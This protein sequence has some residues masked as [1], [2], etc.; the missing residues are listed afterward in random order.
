MEDLA[1]SVSGS[2]QH[3]ITLYAS[4][5]VHVGSRFVASFP[6][7]LTGN[8]QR[9]FGPPWATYIVSLEMARPTS[10]STGQKEV[11]VHPSHV[12]AFYD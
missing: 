6:M 3:S 11:V 7:D 12:R 2:N 4:V 9:R 5:F 1:Q 10:T 8:L